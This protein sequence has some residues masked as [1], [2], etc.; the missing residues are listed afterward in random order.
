MMKFSVAYRESQVILVFLVSLFPFCFVLIP[1]CSNS[2]Y[3]LHARRSLGD[4]SVFPIPITSMFSFRMHFIQLLLEKFDLLLLM[5]S[6]PGHDSFF[7]HGCKLLFIE[8]TRRA[9]CITVSIAGPI[10]GF[11][12]CFK[13][14]LNLTFVSLVH[15]IF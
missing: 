8:N 5:T 1:N 2:T 15:R 6:E 9:A 11:I 13:Q 12:V 14:K 7:F 10:F 3:S 4:A